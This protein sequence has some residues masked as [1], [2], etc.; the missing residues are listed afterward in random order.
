MAAIGLKQFFA[1]QT[2]A[3]INVADHALSALKIF[4]FFLPHRQ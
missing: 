4:G 1:A 2:K 3:L